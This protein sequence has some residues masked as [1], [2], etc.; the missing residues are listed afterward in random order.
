MNYENHSINLD[1]V[2]LPAGKV[3]TGVR[4]A[5]RDGHVLLEIR[6]TD[7]DYE[8]GRLKNIDESV[9]YSNE[10][11]GKHEIELP[12]RLNPFEKHNIGKLYVPQSFRKN[13]YVRFVPSD[14]QTDLSQMMLPVIETDWHGTVSNCQTALSGIGLTYVNDERQ[15]TAG[16]IIPKIFVYEFPIPPLGDLLL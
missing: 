1:D 13:S 15:T 16:A 8:G 14:F 7:L 3:V 4:F 10:E 9:W 5:H 11:G 6:G 2:V 12:N